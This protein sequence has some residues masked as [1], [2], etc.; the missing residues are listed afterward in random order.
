[1]NEDDKGPSRGN[2]FDLAPVESFSYNPLDSS[3]P[4]ARRGCGPGSDRL[5]KIETCPGGS[6]VM[7]RKCF[8]I[9]AVLFTACALFSYAVPPAAAQDASQ[10]TSATPYTI[11]EY[12]AFQACRA[13]NDPT[14]LVKCLDDFVAKYPN[15]SL[16]QYVYQLYYP[17][18]YKLKN[19][20]KSMEYADKLASLGDKIDQATLLNALQTHAQLFPLI[21]DPKAADAKDQLTKERDVSLQGV[22]L[23]QQF[24]KPA[25][26]S[27]DIF[28]KNKKDTATFFFAS[29]GF[30]DLQLKDFAA[31]AEAYKSVLAN[32]PNDGISEY[33]LGI[34]D[35]GLTPPQSLDGFW[36]VAR[37]ISLKVPGDKGIRDYLR[38]QILAYETPGCDNQ[39]DAQLSELLQLAANAPERPSTYTIPSADDL[40][41]VRQ[42]SNIL[43]VITD[44]GGGG[45]KAKLT[46]LAICG[47]D[48]P[49]V[50]GKIIDIQ[51]NTDGSIDFHAYTGATPEDMQAA[52]TANMDVKVWTAAPATPPAGA[53]IT[54]QPDVVRLQ[55]D[56]GIRFSGTLVSYDPSPFLLHWDSVKVDPTIIPEKTETGKHTPHKVPPKKPQR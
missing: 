21:F 9:T 4:L 46:W 47:S 31:A 26:L 12:N 51:T 1:V 14:A 23:I 50:V 42:A 40:N 33:R 20:K 41:K 28:A 29:S 54:P 56:D 52:T 39:V 36:A 7:M 25:G 30:A 11:P 19:Y 18:Y 53:Q 2:G 10:S 15:S 6:Q 16:L 13:E 55:K 17:A 48:F 44:L 8:N 43:T 49:E 32:T 45:D 22:K 37:A 34:A 3:F 35:L 27:D 5:P 24:T 38:A